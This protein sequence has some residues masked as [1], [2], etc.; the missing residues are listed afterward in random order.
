MRGKKGVSGLI[1]AVLLLA[2]SLTIG[3]LVMGW[4]SNYSSE[5]MDSSSAQQVEQDECFKRDFKI[6]SVD[7]TGP[8]GTAD[9]WATIIVENKNDEVIKG[10]LFKFIGS[11][12]GLYAFENKTSI[13]ALGGYVRNTYRLDGTSLNTAKNDSFNYG[14]NSA[15]YNV[16]KV[17]AYPIIDIVVDTTKE[18]VCDGKMKYVDA[19]NFANQ[20]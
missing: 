20:Q 5:N 6:V 11:D 10:F 9:G 15:T 17:E 14:P 19:K 3:G 2:V 16:T 18:V 12:Q 4:I 7:S 13:A 1:V 8:Q